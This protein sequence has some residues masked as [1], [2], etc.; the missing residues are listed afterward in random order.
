MKANDDVS[1]KMK[2]RIA[3]YGTKGKDRHELKTDSAQC[4]STGISSLLHGR[5]LRSISQEFFYRQALLSVIY[6]LLLHENVGV[7]RVTGFC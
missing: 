3:P 7:D 2:A 6:A 4:L 5:L 1:L